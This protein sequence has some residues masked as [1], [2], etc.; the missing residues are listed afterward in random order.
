VRRI[1]LLLSCLLLAFTVGCGSSSKDTSASSTSGASAAATS[2]TGA[3]ASTGTRKFAK[4]RFLLNAGLAYGAF[5]RYIIKPY[6]AG[7]FKQGANGRVAALAKA[8]G[9]GLFVADQLRRAKNNA[10]SDPTLCKLGVPLEKAAAAL[11]GLAAGLKSGS[12]N[13]TDLVGVDSLLNKIG[14]DS[15]GAGAKI[16]NR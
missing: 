4:T 13:P 15:A 14:V 10:V 12:F 3:C 16:Q 7:S 11:T 1:S 5:S 9:S 6:R 8:A 2:S